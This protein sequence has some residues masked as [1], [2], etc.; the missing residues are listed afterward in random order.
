[1]TGVEVGRD[2]DARERQRLAAI[3]RQEDMAQA[4]LDEILARRDAVI[5]ALRWGDNGQ[6]PVMPDAL[7]GATV[8]KQHPRGLSRT[9]IHRIVGRLKDRTTSSNGSDRSGTSD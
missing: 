5:R 7:I 2:L 3:M 4:K 1:M 8:S 9:T 6:G